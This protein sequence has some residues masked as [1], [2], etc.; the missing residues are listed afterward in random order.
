MLSDMPVRLGPRYLLLFQFLD[1]SQKH[2]EIPRLRSGMTNICR[3]E[4]LI[5]PLTFRRDKRSSAEQGR[6]RRRA[7]A[8]RLSHLT[9]ML[10]VNTNFAQSQD[11]HL[12][13]QPV[14][15]FGELHM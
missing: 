13:G 14:E 9:L 15:I 6:G 12:P 8:L 3:L 1:I 4:P 7:P 2:L 11:R 10:V 5:A